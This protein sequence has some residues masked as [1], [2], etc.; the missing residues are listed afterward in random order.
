MKKLKE[1]YENFEGKGHHYNIIFHLL[2]VA[3]L[4][5]LVFGGRVDLDTIISMGTGIIF[6]VSLLLLIAFSLQRY[7]LGSKR[8]IQ[9][10]IF[11]EN[12]IAAAIYQLGIWISL[13]L[14]IS[15]GLM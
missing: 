8:N 2:T 6:N 11:E 14:V 1:S 4:S 13:A 15:K 5:Y 12:N 7:Q 10:E 3:F 9:K